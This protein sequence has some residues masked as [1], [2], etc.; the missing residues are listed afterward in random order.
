M[1]LLRVQIYINLGIVIKKLNK[2][3]AMDGAF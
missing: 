3:A 2:N 1:S